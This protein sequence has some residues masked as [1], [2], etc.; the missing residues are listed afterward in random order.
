MSVEDNSFIAVM[1]LINDPTIKP[2]K[3]SGTVIRANAF[4]GGAPKLIAAS[5][6]EGFNY[7]KLDVVDRTP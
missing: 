3:M 1:K 7:R 6:I 2:G 5:S 4:R